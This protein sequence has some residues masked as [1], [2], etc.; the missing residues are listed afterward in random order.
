MKKRFIATIGALLLGVLALLVPSA[1]A[2]ADWNWG[3][4][5]PAKAQLEPLPSS[6]FTSYKFWPYTVAHICVAVGDTTIPIG[7]MAQAWNNASPYG[8]SL[9]ASNN[10]VNSG[11]TPSTRMTIDTY[12]AADGRC[13]K[14]TNVD[15][16]SWTTSVSSNGFRLWTNNPVGWVNRYYEGCWGTALLRQKWTALVEGRILGMKELTG[17]TWASRVMSTTSA[18][19]AP[20]A[21]T[22][23]PAISDLYNGQ[24]LGWY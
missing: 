3:V 23:G 15:Y 21:S 6:V 12:S 13:Y 8:I 1:P 19:Y 7:A 16:P 10:C 9:T 5:A 11:Y 18:V 14:L 17:S 22:D 20:S 4:A 24:Y 2:H